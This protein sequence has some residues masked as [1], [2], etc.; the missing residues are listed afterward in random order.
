MNRVVLRILK[1]TQVCPSNGS[2]SGSDNS[3]DSDGML[4]FVVMMLAPP[5]VSPEDGAVGMS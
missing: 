2:T 1:Q 5:G 3:M 4:L